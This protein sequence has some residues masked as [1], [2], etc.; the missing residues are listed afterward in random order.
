MIQYRYWLTFV[1]A[2]TLEYYLEF[3]CDGARNKITRLNLIQRLLAAFNLLV[4]PL[5]SKYPYLVATLTFIAQG[6]TIAIPFQPEYQQYNILPDALAKMKSVANKMHE[7]W[8]YVAN[9]KLTEEEIEEEVKNFLLEI[10]N[11]E[12]N[13]QKKLYLRSNS[14]IIAMAKNET[15]EYFKNYG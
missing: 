3:Y 4:L 1:R 13:I 10:E 11:I 6:V 2:K 14:R 15:E 5:V 12:N 9:G 8:H 7:K